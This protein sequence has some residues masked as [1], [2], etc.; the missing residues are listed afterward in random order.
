VGKM[1]YKDK[2]QAKAAP[3]EQEAVEA[4]AKPENEEYVYAIN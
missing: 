2:E 4:K 3:E 1:E